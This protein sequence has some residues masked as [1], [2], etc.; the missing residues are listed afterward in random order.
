MIL[1]QSRIRP[2]VLQWAWVVGLW[3]AFSCAG[4][5]SPGSTDGKRPGGPGSSGDGSGPGSGPNGSDPNSPGA[6]PDEVGIT[7]TDA[8]FTPQ[9]SFAWELYGGVFSRCIGCHNEFGLA[10]QVGV[11]LRMVFPGEPGFADK[12]VSILSQYAQ[13]KVEVAG[14]T[15]PLLLAKPTAQV[16]HVGGEVIVPGSPEALLLTSFIAKLADPP[17]CTETPDDAAATALAGLT[18]AG[19]RE[20]YGR[21]KFILSGELAT[22]E[23]LDALPDTEEMLDQQLDQLMAGE[24]FL[25]RVQEMF[26]DWLLTDAYSSLV[27]GDDLFPQLRDYPQNSYFQPLCTPERD[28]RCCDATTDVCCVN[29]EADPARCTEAANDLAIDAVAREPLELV[30]YIVRN[31]L[32]MTELVTAQYGVANPYS[33]TVY[34]VADAQRGAMFD[35]DVQNDAGEFTP[36]L[37]TPTPQNGLRA[38]GMT[39][40]P[41]SGI[42]SMPVVL[43]RYPSSNSNQQRTRAARLIL[44]RMLAIPVMKLSDFSTAKLPPDADLELA[45]QEYAACTVCHAAID[46]IAGHFRNYGSSGQFRTSGRFRLAEHLPDPAF[47]GTSLP[48]GNT[49]DPLRWLGAQVAKHPRFGLGVLMPVFADLIGTDVLTPPS[50]MV[51]EDYKARYMAFRIQQIEIQRLRREFSGPAALRIKPLV[52]TIVKGPFFRAVGAPALDE[53]T[54]DGLALAGVG[55]GSLLT[56]EQLARKIESLTGLG[57]RSGL[58]AMGRD[59]L[60]SFRDYR[61]MFGGTDW[62]A[63]PQRY[64]EPNAMAVRIAMR[65]GNEMACLAVPQDFALIDAQSRRLFRNADLTTTP[66]SGGEAAIRSDIRR[67]HR[68][69]LNEDL[70]EGDPELEATYQLWVAAHQAASATSG[71][72]SRPSGGMGTRRPRC[73]ATGSFAETPVAYPDATHRVVNQQFD[74]TVRPWMAVIA[75]LLSDGRFFLQ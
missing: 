26:A 8:C 11:Q 5:D 27:R 71:S 34:G 61:L 2:R 18:M 14:E 1:S 31:D 74:S 9:Q 55:L 21:A 12:N 65:M 59:M 50:D 4:A 44:E 41:H 17:T 66:E 22:P 60:R 24:P 10:R 29:V 52:K 39:A 42:L 47:L 75:Y 69:M 16:A 57:Y 68:L 28:F 73:E 58:T 63:T 3:A 51:S 56:P 64:R 35:T 30:R 49:D 23:E 19:P 13:A 53:I 48:E 46:P 20:T 67:L 70:P 38:D 6:V 37:L 25:A 62:D 7:K 36:M 33:A 54:R 72:G 15:I 45:T 32:P 40:Y 43:V